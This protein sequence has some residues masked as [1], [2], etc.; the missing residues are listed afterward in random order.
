MS[1]SDQPD[2]AKT[3]KPA[4]TDGGEVLI[5]GEPWFDDGNIVLQAENTQWRIYRGILSASSSVFADMF[6]IPQ[7]ATGEDLVD[8]CPVVAV[9]DSAQDWKCVLDTLYERRQVVF[10]V[11]CVSF[12]F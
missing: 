1:S 3:I 9:T 10:D 5:R 12:S 6:A 2:P 8:G 11:D 4:S 7:P